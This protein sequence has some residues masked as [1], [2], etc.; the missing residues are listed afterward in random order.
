MPPDARKFN[1]D[2]D[3]Y[4]KN[5]DADVAADMIVM[6]KQWIDN[7]PAFLEISESAPVLQEGD[8]IVVKLRELSEIALEAILVIEGKKSVMDAETKHAA[9]GIF[10]AARQ[11]MAACEIQIVDAVEKIFE[12]AKVK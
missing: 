2:V 7:E 3:C 12:A 5:K 11:P 10:E 4:L 1:L 9:P 8:A 6:L